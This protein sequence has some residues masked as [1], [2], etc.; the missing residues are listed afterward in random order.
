M[1]MLTL[2]KSSLNLIHGLPPTDDSLMTIFNALLFSP[3]EVKLKSFVRKVPIPK[4]TVTK[5]KH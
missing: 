4:A 1:E 2:D 5:V 3:E